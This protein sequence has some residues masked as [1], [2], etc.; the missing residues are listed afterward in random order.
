MGPAI[1][2]VLYVILLVTAHSQQTAASSG[3]ST[4][5]TIALAVML[6]NQLGAL[7]AAQTRSGRSR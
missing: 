4:G 6:A 1:A 5:L 2:T 7:R 3:P